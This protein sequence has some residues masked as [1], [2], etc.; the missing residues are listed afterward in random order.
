VFQTS[1]VTQ[2]IQAEID[3]VPK[4]VLTPSSAQTTLPE[5]VDNSM[6]IYMR[7]VF[8]QKDGSCGQ[9][10]GIGYTYTYEINR[11]RG[12]SATSTTD[13]Q[14]PTHFTYNIVRSYQGMG[15]SWYHQG[16][17]LIKQAGCPN[18]TEYGGEMYPPEMMPWRSRVWES[19]YDLYRDAMPNRVS[20]WFLINATTPEGL[21]DLKHWLNDHN[22]DSTSVG[23]LACF[24]TYMSGNTNWEQIND[25]ISIATELDTQFGY[26]AMTIVG[27]NDT[28]GWDFNGDGILTDTI[29]LNNDNLINMH[30]WE[31]GA[32]KIVNSWGTGWSG[33]HQGYSHIPYKF[34]ADTTY[35]GYPSKVKTIMVV[36]AEDNEKDL[37]LLKAKVAHSIREN[38]VFKTGYAKT[39]D[40][41]LPLTEETIGIFDNHGGLFPVQ[42]RFEN[43]TTPLECALDFGQYYLE[44]DFGKIYLIINE[45]DDYDTCSG[46]IVS[47]SIVDYRWNEE[48][49]LDCGFN[50]IPIENDTDTYLS[51]DYDLI[52]PGDNQIIVSD[53]TLSS[54]M[55]SRFNPTVDSNST[56]V[57]QQG[58][59]VDFYNSTLTIEEGSTLIIEDS[60]VLYGKRGVSNIDIWGNLQLGNNVIFVADSACELILNIK[61][62]DTTILFTVNNATFNNAG[63][64]SSCDSL[65]VS[66]SKFENIAYIKEEVGNLLV[67][68]CTFDNSFVY[69][70]N[71]KQGSIIEIDSCELSGS[72]LFI[73]SYTHYNIHENI[74]SYN[75]SAGVRLYNS[76]GLDGQGINVIKN[77]EIY[78]IGSTKSSLKNT[79]ILLYNT[80]AEI[81]GW[82]YIHNNDYGISCFDFSQTKITGDTVTKCNSVSQRI[83]NNND[84]QV[85]IS[86]ASIPIDFNY[87]E[88]YEPTYS[89]YFIY[90]L[91]QI[92]SPKKFDVTNNFWGENLVGNPSDYIH[93]SL[94]PDWSPMCTY[95][96]ASAAFKTKYDSAVAFISENNYNLAEEKFKEIIEDTLVSNYS[97]ASLNQLFE[98]KK[99]Y[100][101]DFMGLQ[102][103]LV[104][105]NLIQDTTDLGKLARIIS[106]KCDIELENYQTAVNFFEDI[107]LNSGSNQDSIFAII[108][109]GYL[110]LE[111]NNN[112][113]SIVSSMLPQYIP[114]SRNMYEIERDILLDLLYAKNSDSPTDNVEINNDEYNSISDLVLFP[115]PTT[116]ITNIEF[117]INTLLD[118][119]FTVYDQSGRKIKELPTIHCF[120]GNNSQKINMADLKNG[121]YYLSISSNGTS[122]ENRKLILMK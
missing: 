75:T 16:W 102:N 118:L 82:N 51:V 76:G 91:T 27:Y 81:L 29:D 53:D 110:Y 122:I 17:E 95:K 61:S 96:S 15:G 65:Y 105:I 5:V 106:N 73:D 43:D 77:N 107:I 104:S 84:H 80:T 38:L 23:G 12:L 83:I 68:K 18:V 66:N 46:R 6:E 85:Y 13:N 115:N 62:D 8:S 55:V 98:I 42:S 57:I 50:D 97:Y 24:A 26:H 63:L 59:H 37:L 101:E 56:L 108:D 47:Y 35:N 22:E 2:E 111:L 79:G 114:E 78:N 67:S 92:I 32:V 103:Y 34:F 10:S 109:L 1:P 119:S 19:V 74:I 25:T 72:Y 120:E 69:A 31:L 117:H 99:N 39:A 87:N 44:N 20:D 21:D 93:T 121:V 3:Q 45:E 52:V 41:L 89:T 54:N 86:S 94:S 100:D 40:A 7:D 113:A 4:F 71:G 48:F 112:R 90:E 9:A 88:M 60:A 33:G 30:D 49:E 14:Y 58:V 11:L 36:N 116:G 28:I 70:F 64:R